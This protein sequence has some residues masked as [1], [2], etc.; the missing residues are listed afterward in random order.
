MIFRDDLHRIHHD[1][2]ERICQFLGH[3]P[4]AVISIRMSHRRVRVVVVDEQDKLQRV[5][6]KVVQ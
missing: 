5:E 3:D 4:Q 2:F 1:E 6:H